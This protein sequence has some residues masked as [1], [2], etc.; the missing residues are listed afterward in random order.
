[1]I[2]QQGIEIITSISIPALAE[3]GHSF[4]TGHF[5]GIILNAKTVVGN[6][7]NFSQGVTIGGA[8]TEERRGVPQ[9]G[10]NVYIGTNTI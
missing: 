1:M 3:I 2:W 5:G 10:N 6:N 8:G 7:C 4:Y 9:I